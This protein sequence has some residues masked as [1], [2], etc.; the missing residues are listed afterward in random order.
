M[1]Q[2]SVYI[3]DIL[4]SNGDKL[5]VDVFNYLTELSKTAKNKDVKEMVEELL[6]DAF[7]DGE[8]CND[9]YRYGNPDDKADIKDNRIGNIVDSDNGASFVIINPDKDFFAIVGYFDKFILHCGNDNIVKDRPFDNVATETDTAGGGDP[10]TPYYDH[11]KITYSDS[12]INDIDLSDDWWEEFYDNLT[13]TFG[14]VT[15]NL[16]SMIDTRDMDINP[17]KSKLYNKYKNIINDKN[18]FICLNCIW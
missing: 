3:K 1:K 2:L 12:S 6:A 18:T 8:F 13:G 7:Y 9:Y 16:I 4:E 14:E 17:N 10:A 5:P 11:I 15:A